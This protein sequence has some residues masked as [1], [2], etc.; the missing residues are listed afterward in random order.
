MGDIEQLEAEVTR[1]KEELQRA[2]VRLDEARIAA[3]PWKIGDIIEATTAN[4]VA[5]SQHRIIA[6]YNAKCGWPYVVSR[7]ADGSWGRRGRILHRE[8]KVIGHDE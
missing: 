8:F 4:D 7:R 1:L 2:R 3:L 6:V 5:S